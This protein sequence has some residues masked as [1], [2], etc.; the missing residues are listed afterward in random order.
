[1]HVP[2]HY[3]ASE[4]LSVE[5]VLDI[6]GE[7]PPERSAQLR[8][9]NPSVEPFLPIQFKSVEALRWALPVLRE[10]DLNHTQALIES[11]CLPDAPVEVLRLEK[12]L[13]KELTRAVEGLGG[14]QVSRRRKGLVA[15]AAAN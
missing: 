15:A 2:R 11:Q 13:E 4:P 6:F 12:K 1:M 10:K 14:L 3:L 5:A 9:L 7:S 8:P